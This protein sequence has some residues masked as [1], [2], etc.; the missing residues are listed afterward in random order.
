MSRVTLYRADVESPRLARL[1][2]AV[3]GVEVAGDGDAD[4]DETAPPTTADDGGLLDRVPDTDV[5]DEEKASMV[6]TYGLLGLGVSMVAL[7]IA[8][9]GIWVY[10]RRKGDDEGAETPPPATGL[11]TVDEPAVTEPSTPAPPT[12]PTA[13]EPESATEEPRGR[14]E[15]RSDVE[16]TTRETTPTSEPE[17]AAEEAEPSDAEPR[18][19]ESV[20][21]APLLGVAFLAV[22]GAVVRWVQGGEGEA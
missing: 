21:A 16:W 10:L 7:G 8:T 13:V 18:P 1:V 15:D 11:D 2:G 4:S 20:D 19:G 14:T 6:K 22:T 17:T 12:D 9:V 5:V 3:P